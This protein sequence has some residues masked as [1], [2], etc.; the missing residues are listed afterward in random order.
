[1]TVQNDFIL[2]AS[3]STNIDDQ[4]T[5]AGDTNTSA[6]RGSGIWPSSTMNKMLRQATWG[7][8]LIALLLNDKGFNAIDDG[9]LTTY[10]GYF[11]NA[12]ALASFPSGTVMSFFQATA[13]TGWTQNVT[14]NDAILRVVSG[15]GGGAKTNG[16][17]LSAT[18]ASVQTH[19]ISQAE[20]PN[21]SFPV[22]DPGHVHAVA[23][24]QG[25]G[26]NNGLSVFSNTNYIEDWNTRSHTTGISVHSGGSGS[27]H[28]H[29]GNNLNINYCD[30]ILA[31]KN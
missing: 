4:S 31:Q 8:A 12:I 17:G 6:G 22:T 19:A 24:Y 30:M 2:Y 11:E 9:T 13:P 20:L 26:G 23:G 27:A 7:S 28:G 10:K 14:Y 1:M 18:T 3:A 21:V 5:Y 25:T 29:T 15:T 16:T